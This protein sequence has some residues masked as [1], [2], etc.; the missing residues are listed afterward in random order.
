VCVC[1]SILRAHIAGNAGH[2]LKGKL[3]RITG[4]DPANPLYRYVT[5][6]LR[7]DKS[8]AKFVDVIH[9]NCGGPFGQGFLGLEFP[10]AHADF[11]PNNGKS[12]P[13]WSNPLTPSKYIP[14]GS[15]A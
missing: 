8:D 5:N 6:D 3:G 10:L 15:S 7:L 13:G 4:L 14:T 2:K 11:Y 12:Q 9:T 1:Y